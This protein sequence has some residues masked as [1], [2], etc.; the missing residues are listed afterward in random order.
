[1]CIAQQTFTDQ[2]KKKLFFREQKFSNANFRGENSA[3]FRVISR[4][5]AQTTFFPA[6]FRGETPR[7]LAEKRREL[8]QSFSA[9]F[10]KFR[11]ENSE[12]FQKML[13]V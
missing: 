2:P 4:N 1:M 10:A 5:F 6:K 13:T 7:K 9:Q 8:S 3:R 11:R 12:S